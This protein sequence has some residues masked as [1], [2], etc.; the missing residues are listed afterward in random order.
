MFDKFLR[1]KKVYIIKETY[2]VIVFDEPLKLSDHL[3]TNV[4]K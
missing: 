3:L 4:K 1:I 2:Q